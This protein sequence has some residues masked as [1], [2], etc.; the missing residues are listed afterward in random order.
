MVLELSTGV[1]DTTNIEI[2]KSPNASI[3][4]ETDHF[5]PGF[6]LLIMLSRD[7]IFITILDTT[8]TQSQTSN[9]KADFQLV[10]KNSFTHQDVDEIYFE[11]GY[12]N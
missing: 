2:R 6:S 5:S 8:L 4:R 9:I 10:K 3:P 1:L 7:N 11:K 12:T